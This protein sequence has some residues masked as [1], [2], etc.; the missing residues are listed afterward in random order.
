M[1]KFV[2]LK[3]LFDLEKT[4]W[5]FI[6][7]TVKELTEH[8]KKYC[9][10]AYMKIEKKL[11]K[12]NQNLDKTA[13]KWNT[14]IE[15]KI[16]KIGKPRKT[17]IRIVLQ[18][19]LEERKTALKH[20]GYTLCLSKGTSWSI[21]RNKKEL[22][23][24]TENT[25][26]RKALQFPLQKH[27]VFLDIADAKYSW[28]DMPEMNIRGFHW[29]VKIGNIDVHDKNGNQKWGSRTEAEAAAKW[30]VDEENRKRRL[31]CA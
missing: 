4:E 12:N 28:W 9:I 18:E 16:E 10:P 6:P 27:S 7:K 26:E 15:N 21:I 29:Y 30:F 3:N 8:F 20:L 1:Y 22:E 11:G 24:R 17:V 31:Q 19:M 13:S 14:A 5:Q 2:K 25:V 23:L